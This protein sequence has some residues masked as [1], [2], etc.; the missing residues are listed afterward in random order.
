MLS[1]PGRIEVPSWLETERLLLR[2]ARTGDGPAVF[3]A[4]SESLPELRPWMRWAVDPP[5]LA[6]IEANLR[7]AEEEF[8]QGINFRF[9]VFLK[10]SNILVGSCGLHDPD[11]SVP[12][13][14]IG[15]WV[16]TSYAGQGY[17]HETV[18][19]LSAMAFG[20]LG[21]RRLQIVCNAD[22]ARSTAVARRAGFELE[23]V[24]RNSARHHLSGELYDEMIFSKVR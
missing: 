13:F 7:A 9:L 12:A 3:E 5:V 1:M 14:E 2:C 4:I 17:I 11:W 10:G 6:N 19:S 23:G 16:R 18:K 20:Q 8:R 22:N 21:A 24:R 15:Y